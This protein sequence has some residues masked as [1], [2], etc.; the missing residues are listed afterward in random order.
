MSSINWPSWINLYS[1][2]IQ[3]FIMKQETQID[4]ENWQE[5]ILPKNYDYFFDDIYWAFNRFQSLKSKDDY[6]IADEVMDS[7]NVLEAIT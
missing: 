5:K 1:Y 4:P 3:K 2:G 7:S 6:K